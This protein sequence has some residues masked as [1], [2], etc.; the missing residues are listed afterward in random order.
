LPAGW[1]VWNKNENHKSTFYAEYGS[2]GPGFV[3]ESRIDWSKQ[4][5]KKEAKKY[6]LK[7]IFSQGTSWLPVTK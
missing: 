7:N 6:T 4:L 3:K 1:S 5:T 2:K